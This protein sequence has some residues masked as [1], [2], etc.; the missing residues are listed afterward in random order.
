VGCLIDFYLEY[1]QA[2][3]ASECFQCQEVA[4]LE[5]ELRSRVQSLAGRKSDVLR[6]DSQLAVVT[7]SLQKVSVVLLR[8]FISAVKLF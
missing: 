5:A 2:S 3:V 1:M 8:I 7:S 4:S 6:L